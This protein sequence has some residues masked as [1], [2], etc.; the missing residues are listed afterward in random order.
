MSSEV[1]MLIRSSENP[2]EFT[3]FI[4]IGARVS[5]SIWKAFL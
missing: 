3:E 4:P 2:V 1:A 5:K